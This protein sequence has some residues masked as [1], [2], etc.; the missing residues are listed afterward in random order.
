VDG[1]TCRRQVDWLCF[2]GHIC[3]LSCKRARSKLALFCQ[4][5]YEAGRFDTF[6][7]SFFLT[8]FYCCLLYVFSDKRITVNLSN[9]KLGSFVQIGSQPRATVLQ[10]GFVSYFHGCEIPFGFVFCVNPFFELKMQKFGFVLHKQSVRQE[11]RAK[12]NNCRDVVFGMSCF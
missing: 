12:C 1:T 10:F 4:N 3:L 9:L 7:A 8:P 6:L 11:T 2:V 5:H